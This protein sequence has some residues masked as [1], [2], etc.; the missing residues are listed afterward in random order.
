MIFSKSVVGDASDAKARA[1]KRSKWHCGQGEKREPS[2][3]KEKVCAS[4]LIISIYLIEFKIVMSLAGAEILG[5][6]LLSPGGRRF[7]LTVTVVTPAIACPA[8]H[9]DSKIM[10]CYLTYEVYFQLCSCNFS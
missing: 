4:F 3:R 1:A 8:R 2:S 6:R 7:V 5:F 10:H 9:I